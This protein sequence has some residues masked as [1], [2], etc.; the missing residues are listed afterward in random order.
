MGA[1]TKLK[2]T[3]N[4][5]NK[6]SI[7]KFFIVLLIFMC[8]LN[9]FELYS[10]KKI[11]VTGGVSLKWSYNNS[12]LESQGED[13]VVSDG[14]IGYLA[15]VGI[16]WSEDSGF[17]T[18]SR[19]T[20]ENFTS[21]LQDWERTPIGNVNANIFR[22]DPAVVHGRIK[23]SKFLY[24]FIPA[25]FSIYTGKSTL[26]PGSYCYDDGLWYLIQD[27][28][29]V[30]SLGWSLLGGGIDYEIFPHIQIGFE[31]VMI[32]EDRMKVRFHTSTTDI[33]SKV[34]SVNSFLPF[35]LKLTIRF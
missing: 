30:N 23:K 6:Y 32:E 28:E 21:E 12:K 8:F 4:S 15:T 3:T 11:M 16:C 29:M 13:N 25:G 33:E 27:M 22:I 35:K 18:V 5:V 17:S 1:V 9:N 20:Y 7:C 10:Q 31:T 24:T 2:N 19:I 34:T 14:N 26:I